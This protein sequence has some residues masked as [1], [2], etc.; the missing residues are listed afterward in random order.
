MGIVIRQSL[1]SST[2]AYIG[3]AIGAIN[4]LFIFPKFLTTDEVGLIRVI[5]S[6]AFLLAT[7]AQLGLPQ[8]ILKFLPTFDSNDQKK[9]EFLGFTMIMAFIGYLL[10]LLLVYVFKDQIQTYFSRKSPLFVQYFEVSLVVTF[11]LLFIQI[12]EAYSRA[13]LKSVPPVL[14]RDV[15]LRLLTTISIVLYGFE[16]I[17]FT[18]FINLFMILYGVVLVCHVVHFLSIKALKIGL[19]FEKFSNADL[20]KILKYGAFTLIGASGTQIVLQVDSLMVAGIEGLDATGIY[21]IAFFIGTVIE[22]PKRSITQI[23][24]PLISQAFQRG[25]M[26]EVALLYRQTSINQLI[27]GGLLWLGVW[28]NLDSIYYLMPNS[29]QYILGFN[30]VLLIGLGKLTD[31]LFGV[32]GEIIVMSKYY[33]FNVFAV[34]FLAAVLVVGNSLL[35]PRYGIDGAA[36][37]S[38][39]AMLLFNLTKFVFVFVKFGIQPFS[40]KTALFLVVAALVGLLNSVIPQFENVYLDVVLRS[41]LITTLLIGPTYLLRISPELNGI[42]NRV[43]ASLKSSN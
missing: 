11:F 17:E 38:L 1:R 23:T 12:S 32:N 10:L 6:A 30:V 36:M 37:A 2:L 8:G 41:M 7:F 26:R 13:L 29:D 16:V 15:V 31:M 28:A 42:L 43:L 40:S 14:F 4:F 24:T 33:K 18:L 5:P 9:K 34:A 25:D 39:G 20:K 3:F 22:I 35:I 19:R 21:A 27:I